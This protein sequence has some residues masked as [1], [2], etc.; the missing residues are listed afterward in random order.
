V[1]KLLLFAFILASIF[2]SAQEITVAAASDLQFAFQD[3]AARF[4]KETNH[5]VKLTFGSSGISFLRFRMV[6]R[7]MCT[8]PPISTI[9]NG[10]KRPD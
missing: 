8:S 3:V 6:R 1:K 10:L 9:P 4:Q 2:C 7:L 5:P